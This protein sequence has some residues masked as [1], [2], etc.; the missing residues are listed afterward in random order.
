MKWDEKIEWPDPPPLNTNIVSEMEGNLNILT[1]ST[2]NFSIDQSEWCGYSG[3]CKKNMTGTWDICYICK[4]KKKLD[5]PAMLDK[6]YE[7][8]NGIQ[9]KGKI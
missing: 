7:E 4:Y 1:V 8:Q 6:A 9:V 3:E 5:I 2:I